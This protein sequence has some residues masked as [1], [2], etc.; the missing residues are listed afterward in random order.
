MA[1]TMETH[2]ASVPLPRSVGLSAL[3][4]TK[5]AKCENV[6]GGADGGDEGG[7]IGGDGGPDGKGLALASSRSIVVATCPNAEGMPPSCKDTAPTAWYQ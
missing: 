7:S 2:R 4:D 3:V 5:L 6:G 1:A